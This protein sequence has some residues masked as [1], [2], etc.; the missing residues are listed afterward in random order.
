MY[1]DLVVE[2][3]KLK[4][5]ISRKKIKGTTY[6]YYEHGRK[7]YAGKQYTVPQCTSIG[8]VCEDDPTMMYPNGN[9]LNQ[10]IYIDSTIS[11][12]DQLKFFFMC[13]RNLSAIGVK[14]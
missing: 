10:K 8:K 12:M 9:F 4:T 14:T 1:L 11:N 2:I 13:S 6:I 5:G 7:Y 3:P